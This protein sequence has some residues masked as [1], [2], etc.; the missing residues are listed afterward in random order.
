MDRRQHGLLSRIHGMLL[1]IQGQFL[2]YFWPIL[3]LSL[4]IYAPK[5]RFLSEWR[6]ASAAIIRAF[7]NK[8][9]KKGGQP[10]HKEKR[11][12]PMQP[13]KR[14][15][16]HNASACIFG[17]PGL[18]HGRAALFRTLRTVAIFWKN[19]RPSLAFRSSLL[20]QDRMR[21]GQSKKKRAFSCFVRAFRYLCTPIYI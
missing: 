12:P 10:W 19:K 15:K 21:L 2:E 3:Q 1:L 18:K 13:T 11:K 16:K 6:A 4:C 5:S 20:R 7:A 14:L 17:L 8:R 9:A